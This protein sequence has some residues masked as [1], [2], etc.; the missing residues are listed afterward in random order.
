MIK[1]LISSSRNVHKIIAVI[2]FIYNSAG[3]LICIFKCRIDTNPKEKLSEAMKIVRGGLIILTLLPAISIFFYL[4]RFTRN[5]RYID[6][7]I[8]SKKYFKLLIGLLISVNLF[9]IFK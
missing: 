4:R 6:K 1:S 7:R 5:L 8:T 9:R 2:A 3:I